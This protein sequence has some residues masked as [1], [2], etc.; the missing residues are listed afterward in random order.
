MEM[1]PPLAEKLR[2]DEVLRS[3]PDFEAMPME[4]NASKT[5]C[6]NTRHSTWGCSAAL[7]IAACTPRGARTRRC[8]WAGGGCASPPRAV[9][10]RIR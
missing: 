10:L 2:K 9:A 6:T 3:M 7:T 8:K 4:H 1:L 5:C